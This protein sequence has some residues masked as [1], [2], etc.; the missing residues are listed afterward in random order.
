MQNHENVGNLAEGIVSLINNTLTQ[1]NNNLSNS[2]EK[3]IQNRSRDEN[4]R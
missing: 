2:I 3:K 4:R 1:V